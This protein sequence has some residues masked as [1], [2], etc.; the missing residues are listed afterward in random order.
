MNE[1]VRSEDCFEM[2]GVVTIAKAALTNN[3]VPAD[4]SVRKVYSWLIGNQGTAAAGVTFTIERGVEI[5]RTV[6]TIVLGGLDSLDEQ[7]ELGLLSIPGGSDI[8]AQV[9]VGTGPMSVCLRCFEL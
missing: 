8:K 3:V 5:L 2:E 7:S 9:T 6:P 4:K 1:R